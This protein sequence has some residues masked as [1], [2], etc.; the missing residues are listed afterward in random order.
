[1]A[2]INKSGKVPPNTI[3]S[4]KTE[5]IGARYRQETVSEFDVKNRIA[6]L[7]QQLAELGELQATAPNE[8]VSKKIAN[9]ERVLEAARSRQTHL[10]LSRGIIMTRGLESLVSEMT[11]S[12]GIEREAAFAAS[13]DPLMIGA[14]GLAMARPM[15]GESQASLKQRLIKEKQNIRSQMKQNANEYESASEKYIKET[16]PEKQKEFAAERA[17][18]LEKRKGLSSRLAAT[19]SSL[20]YI[21]EDEKTQIDVQMSAVQKVMNRRR[22]EEA[23]QHV[24]SGQ[25]TFFHKY[26]EPKTLGDLTPKELRQRERSLE[27]DIAKKHEA[28]GAA[29]IKHDDLVAG[30]KDATEAAKELAKALEELKSSTVELQKTQDAAAAGGGGGFFK[31][32]IT[33]DP[34]TLSGIGTGLQTVGRLGLIGAETAQ[35]VLVNRPNMIL[36]NRIRAA[37]ASNELYDLR[38][39]ALS[40]DM[41]ALTLLDSDAVK[42][43]QEAAT[44][45]RDTMKYIGV[46]KGASRGA[47]ALGAGFEFAGGMA[48][49][50]EDNALGSIVG[51]AVKG[52]G[53][54]G[55][56]KG[57]VK[58]TLGYGFTDPSGSA[59]LVNTAAQTSAAV[60]ELALMTPR[61]E[62]EGLD[63]YQRQMQLSKQLV[64]V[65]G[66][67]RQTAYNFF[68][69]NVDTAGALGVSAGNAFLQQTSGAGAEANLQKMQQFGIGSEQFNQLSAFGAA[70]MGSTFSTNQ[71]FAARNIER[72]GLGTMQEHMQRQ[73]MMAQAGANNPQASYASVL[74]TAMSKGLDS[75]KVLN[76][77]AQSTAQTAQSSQGFM[78]TGL[79]VTGAAAKELVSMVS[80]DAVNKEAETMRAM[81]TREKVEQVATDVSS[82]FTGMINVGRIQKTTGLG[83]KQAVLA[84]QMDSATLETLSEKVR[85]AKTDEEKKAAATAIRKAG[86]SDLVNKETGMVDVE[87]LDALE[88]A[89]TVQ[90]LMM[91]DKG[92]ASGLTSRK[93]FKEFVK[94][95]EKKGGDPNKILAQEKYSALRD[96]YYTTAGLMKTDAE[97]FLRATQK[98][99]EN[100]TLTPEQQ[101]AVGAAQPGAAPVDISKLPPERQQAE[102]LR[103]AEGKQQVEEIKNASEAMKGFSNLM[104]AITTATEELQKK[105]TEGNEKFAKAA[106]KAA[107][108]FSQSS[109]VFTTG[110]NNLG[111]ILVEAAD[112]IKAGKWPDTNSG[113]R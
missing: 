33:G 50:I 70:E 12:Q 104:T 1:M 22:Q 61:A 72:A 71:V 40:G 86:L 59:K 45:R 74:E 28:V 68:R 30:N 88:K 25:E 39:A 91:G 62:S 54:A 107:T 43:A 81:S 18:I 67:Q 53:I 14:Q 36:N 96:E 37:Q 7:E 20:S 94:E 31:K 75:S 102:K 2:P 97:Q 27:E 92:I 6:D 110:L 8:D 47:M 21:G 10:K 35:T 99:K 51:G 80:P 48:Q 73:A 93:D 83:Y 90:K 60:E 84:G 105:G 55:A 69:G 85:S 76:I 44:S 95:Y 89:K 101:A 103:T 26:F 11:S 23:R 9:V 108:D 38:K 100:S 78:T 111:K 112:N 77:I 109:E 29:K 52:G 32:M 34:G 13:Q 63:E 82:S 56:I 16:D 4:E 65:T 49:N 41:S 24:F 42:S 113:K 87:R 58:S 15:M 19:E 17:S 98:P 66:Q 79:D 3:F 64:Y 106:A 57:A 46:A 5:Q